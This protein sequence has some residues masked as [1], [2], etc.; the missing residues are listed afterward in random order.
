MNDW[1]EAE[2]RVERAQ[3]LSESFRWAEAL[4]E[5]EVAL[6]INPNNAAWHAHRGYILE[7]LGCWEDAAQAYGTALE[8]E[9]GDRDVAVAFG[10]GLCRLD[11]FSRALKVFE[12]LGRLYPDFEPAYCH[13]IGI[14]AELG[15]H[16][17]A[18]QMFY[19]AQDLNDSCPHCF[20][21]MGT[22]LASRAQF[23]RAIYC[24]QRVLE[25][26][27][28]YIGVN[29]RIAQAHRAQGELDVAKEY[30]L[31]EVRDDPGNTDLLY[32]LAELTLESGQVEMAAAKFA[33]IVELDP[34]NVESQLA[35]GRTWLLRNQPGRAL[36]CFE[37]V[38]SIT[39]GGSSLPGFDFMVGEAL[40]RLG[41]FA[42]AR[43]HLETAVEHDPKNADVLMSLGDCWFAMNKPAGAADAFR[44]VLALDGQNPLAHHKLGL[45]LFQ[46][47][48]HRAGLEHCLHAVRAKPDYVPAMFAAVFG[49]LHLAQWREARSMLRR[50]LRHDPE[51]PNLQRLHKRLWRYRFRRHLQR[52][53]SPFGWV[54][55][56]FDF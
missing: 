47:G 8:L 42:E 52:L 41:R 11:Q 2:Q 49:H 16:D 54:R 10:A 15:R 29:R 37:A 55:R 44:R 14:Y 24:W 40:L 51:N 1:L 20:F 28:E 13:R 21:H 26:E 23:D 19:L 17:Q 3:Q 27:P 34:T 6:E 36:A 56:R 5:I 18:E 48:H 33:Q 25:L 50:A 45:C 30:Y 9:P 39:D 38:G 35:L 7:E 53:G 22:S 46:L 12:E 32:E 4:A 43:G 31:R